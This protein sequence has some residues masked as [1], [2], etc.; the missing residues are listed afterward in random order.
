[1]ES[2]LTVIA[3][4]ERAVGYPVRALDKARLDAAVPLRL[5][6]LPDAGTGAVYHLGSPRSSV[7]SSCS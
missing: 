7:G 6:L 1:M 2:G 3:L 4:L 5:S